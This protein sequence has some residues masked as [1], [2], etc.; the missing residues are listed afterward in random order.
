MA[1]LAQKENTC[2][3][4]DS[5]AEKKS[6]LNS[7]FIWNFTSYLW[8]PLSVIIWATIIDSLI[9]Q[10]VFTHLRL[11]DEENTSNLIVIAIDLLTHWRDSSLSVGTTTV[12]VGRRFEDQSCC[13]QCFSPWRIFVGLECSSCSVM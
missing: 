9:T 12:P 6:G 1:S 8:L 2:N 7:Y 3:E 11:L 13:L 10:T 4:N 5:I